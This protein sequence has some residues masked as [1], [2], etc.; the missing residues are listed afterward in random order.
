MSKSL[1][2]VGTALS[3][4]GLFA[5]VLALIGGL[6]GMHTMGI[7]HAKAMA[8]ASMAHPALVLTPAM[9]GTAGERTTTSHS[10]GQANL[11]A[12][13]AKPALHG[14]P[15]GCGF[16]PSDDHASMTGH[17]TCVP[18]FG[19]DFLGL[20]TPGALTWTQVRT[21]FTRAPGPK[22]MG[23]VPDPPSL[24]QLSINRT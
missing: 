22:S 12:G 4:L 18:S 15:I 5:V 10:L 9:E 2:I 17:G 19:P 16:S 24:I 21:A 1:P 20:P 11:V 23:R 14:G 7:V 3:R 13:M 8:S 6:L